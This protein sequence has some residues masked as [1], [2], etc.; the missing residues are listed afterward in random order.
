MK[1]QDPINRKGDL[2]GSH[3]D[4]LAYFPG[5]S[6]NDAYLWV[7]HEYLHPGSY[8]HI[9]KINNSWQVNIDSEKNFRIDAKTPMKLVA[10]RAIEG[11]NTAVGMTGNCSGGKT[12]W[13]TILTCE[14]N[15]HDFYG[16]VKF[17]KKGKK[18]KRHLIAASHVMAWD[19]HYPHAP[20]HYGWSLVR[21]T[22]IEK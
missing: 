17:S 6:A 16:Q 18:W 8:L 3:N 12:P 4:F 7:N 20:E 22:P 13:G 15:F 21:A 2:F 10:D 1:W 19:D 5:A 11:S 14:E 9:Q